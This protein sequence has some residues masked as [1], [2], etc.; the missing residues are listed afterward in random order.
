VVEGSAVQFAHA[1]FVNI[2][3]HADWETAGSSGADFEPN[4]LAIP[5][6]LDA[7]GGGDGV[8]QEP[9][10]P[11]VRTRPGF[12]RVRLEYWT[13]ID[14]LHLDGVLP[15]DTDDH[16]GGRVSVC[17]TDRVGHDLTREQFGIGNDGLR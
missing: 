13:L 8:D 12:S 4:L 15:F 17:V 9:S 6:G 16:G 3:A 11:S 2:S 1:S 14:D 10:L 5:F 7:P